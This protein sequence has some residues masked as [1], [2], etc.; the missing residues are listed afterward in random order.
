MG[1]GFDRITVLDTVFA[2]LDAS[3]VVEANEPT[4]EDTGM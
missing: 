3:V 2:V 1:K 4:L